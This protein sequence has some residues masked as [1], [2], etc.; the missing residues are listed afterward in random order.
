MQFID[1]VVIEVTAGRGGDG[2]AAFRREKFRPMG[3]PCGGDGGRGGDIIL[4]GDSGLSTL[5]ELKYSPKWRA[6]RG[7]NGKG[8]DMFGKNAPATRVRVPLGTRVK[9]ADSGLELADIREH[10]QEFTAA[11]GGRGG[12][13]NLSFKTSRRTAPDWAE[14]GK[15]GEHRRLLLELMLIADVGL[16]GFPNAGKSTLIRRVSA[17]RPK[18]ADYPFTTLVPNLG[19]VRL[20][21]N[22]SFVMADIPG[23]I[24]GASG[25]AGLGL[26]FLRHIERTRVIC[27][28]LDLGPEAGA[29]P[30]KSFETVCRELESYSKT[31]S[32]R[33]RVVVINKIDMAA[34][35]DRIGK[36]RQRFKRKKIT[37]HAISALTGEGV[38]ELM[39][40][41]WKAL[42]N[43][44]A[45][46]TREAP[47]SSS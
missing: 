7:E 8:K 3:G 31:L 38:Q 37:L 21:E 12:R 36:I 45:A 5:I 27:H 11:R 14:E 41:L 40:I 35:R 2:C 28:M 20:D 34:V 24:E 19:V 47:V 4:V 42:E 25:G 33:P 23:I 39:E 32:E 10:G 30:L 15:R 1:E 9:D 17:A 18:V 22:R 29:D 44:T 43:R 16:A 13:G 6:R 26:R 46:T